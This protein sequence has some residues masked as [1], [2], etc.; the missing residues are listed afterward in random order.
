MKIKFIVLIVS[1]ILSKFSNC[2]TTGI[3]ITFNLEGKAFSSVIIATDATDSIMIDELLQ[4]KYRKFGIVLYNYAETKANDYSP[5][6]NYF[7]KS[8]STILSSQENIE[9]ENVATIS[10]L[11]QAKE[12]NQYIHF[13]TVASTLSYFQNFKEKLQEFSNNKDLLRI[14]NDRIEVINALKKHN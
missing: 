3:L 14:I 10:I 1:I 13:K 6:L 11:R 12:Q 7:L 5:I 8:D 2:Q 4:M 9:G